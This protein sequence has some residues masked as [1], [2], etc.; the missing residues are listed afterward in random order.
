MVSIYV[1]FGCPADDGRVLDY[2]RLSHWSIH[3]CSW[4]N[5]QRTIGVFLGWGRKLL[6]W[7]HT[8]QPLLGAAS[9]NMRVHVPSNIFSWLFVNAQVADSYRRIDSTAALKKLRFRFLGS[10]DFHIT[11]IGSP[12]FC[13]PDFNIYRSMKSHYQG[14]QS[15]QHSL[16]DFHL[17]Q[18]F[19]FNWAGL[20]FITSVFFAFTIQLKQRIV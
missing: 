5:V 7:F 11:F 4:N 15:Y 14:I 19:E 2:T 9:K 12:S 16:E 6:V 17:W 10:V 3:P 20:K 8:V 1:S 18:L 13:N